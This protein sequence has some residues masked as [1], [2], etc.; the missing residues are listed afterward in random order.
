MIL[1][2][3]A[4]ELSSHW[5][6]IYRRGRAGGDHPR[7]GSA[8]PP[9]FEFEF[10]FTPDRESYCPKTKLFRKWSEWGSAD[11]H[12]IQIEIVF[13]SRQGILL[14]HDRIFKNQAR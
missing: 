1:L 4:V 7:W 10:A 12:K 14:V 6:S 8:D 9:T 2:V 11:P 3:W 5:G 13:C